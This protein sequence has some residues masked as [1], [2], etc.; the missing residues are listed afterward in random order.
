VW[1]EYMSQALKG[2][3]VAEP[4]VPEGVINVAGEWY[5]DE[6]SPGQ[7]ISTLGTEDAPAPQAPTEDEKK[8]I[9]DLFRWGPM[10]LPGAAHRG[11]SCS[12]PAK[13]DPRKRHGLDGASRVTRGR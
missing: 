7:G 5:Y 8:G 11:G 6:Y 2:V 1:I 3:P 4:K 13:P 12:G 10:P 9:L